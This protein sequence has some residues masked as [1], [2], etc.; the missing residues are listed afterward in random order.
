MKIKERVAIY[1][2]HLLIIFFL[3]L[4][5]I[6]RI[7]RYK[8]KLKRIISL[9]YLKN[10]KTKN[11]QDLNCAITAFSLT[12]EMNY[13]CTLHF[14]MCKITVIPV[15][16]SVTLCHSP[17]VHLQRAGTMPNTRRLITPLS[18]QESPKERKLDKS[19]IHQKANRCWQYNIY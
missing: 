9:F 19:F 14:P 3:N 6:Q 7:T 18:W 17:K 16:I 5:N 15:S 11:S 4:E 8:I 2:V 13:A 12:S 1:W 10:I